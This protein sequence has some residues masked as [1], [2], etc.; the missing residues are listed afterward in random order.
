MPAHEI[1]ISHTDRADVRI[2]PIDDRQ[3]AAVIALNLQAERNERPRHRDAV[4]TVGDWK[5]GG[6]SLPLLPPDPHAI[7]ALLTQERADAPDEGRFP[8]LRTRLRAQYPG[9][10]S[11]R[12]WEQANAIAAAAD[13]RPLPMPVTAGLN[14]EAGEQSTWFAKH[15]AAVPVAATVALLIRATPGWLGAL[16]LVGALVTGHWLSGRPT[17]SSRGDTVALGLYL[18][19]LLAVTDLAAT[20]VYRLT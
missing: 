6:Q 9:L 17:G 12:L 8:D 18:G 16:A 19:L 10:Q 7:A 3:Q 5:P 15:L 13:P 2:G 14:E 11:T 4:I 1:R 20:A